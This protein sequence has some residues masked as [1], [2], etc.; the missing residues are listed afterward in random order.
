MIAFPVARIEIGRSARKVS[1]A[2]VPTERVATRDVVEPQVDQSGAESLSVFPSFFS[3]RHSEDA[4]RKILT[5]VDTKDQYRIEPMLNRDR[6]LKV[7]TKLKAVLAELDDAQIG[8]ILG[9]LIDSTKALADPVISMAQW[10]T[11]SLQLETVAGLLNKHANDKLPHLAYL[12][13]IVKKLEYVCRFSWKLQ[14]YEALIEKFT[15]AFVKLIVTNSAANT[16]R[17]AM[18]TIEASLPLDI[19]SLGGSLGHQISFSFDDEG[20]GKTY[21]ST[22]GDFGARLKLPFFKFGGKISGLTGK[23]DYCRTAR[24]HA[25]CYFNELLANNRKSPL[26]NPY[27]SRRSTLGVKDKANEVEDFYLVQKD[28]VLTEK[29]IA[30]NFS[31]FLSLDYSGSLVQESEKLFERGYDLV[32]ST[33]LRENQLILHQPQ[34]TPR[35]EAVQGAKKKAVVVNGKI[36]TKAG[37]LSAKA[38][39]ETLVV[40]ASATAQGEWSERVTE[41]TRYATLCELLDNKPANS[42]EVFKKT[43][44]RDVQAAGFAI[45]KKVHANWYPKRKNEVALDDVT[46]TLIAVEYHRHPENFTPAFVSSMSHEPAFARYVSKKAPVLFLK[47]DVDLL[48]ADFKFLEDLHAQRAMGNVNVDQSIA[49]F[50]KIYDAANVE[51]CL[52][53]MAV[54]TAYFYEQLGDEKPKEF[55]ERLKNLETRIFATGIPHRPDVLRKI[56]G[57]TQ[58]YYSVTSDKTFEFTLKSEFK[59]LF[60]RTTAPGLGFKWNRKELSHYNPSRSGISHNVDLTLSGTA[61]VDRQVMKA[62]SRYLRYE[63]AY[64][65][66]ELFESDYFANLSAKGTYAVRYFLPKDA[67]KMQMVKLDSRLIGQLGF[68]LSPSVPIGVPGFGNIAV[69]V[70]YSSSATT[71]LKDMPSPD[72]MYYFNVHYM[73]A[74]FTGTIPMNEETLEE[75]LRQKGQDSYWHVLVRNHRDALAQL[76]VNIAQGKL[77]AEFEHLKSRYLSYGA[78][79]QDREKVEA[80]QRVFLASATHFN[81]TEM[82]YQIALESF[83]GFMRTLYKHWKWTRELSEAF[84]PYQYEFHSTLVV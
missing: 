27:L 6:A 40:E 44:Q 46:C 25:I 12:K 30:D 32:P 36:D 76:F 83:K 3:R 37:V 80:A 75:D 79:K 7:L 52:K 60:M 21:R 53:N 31:L 68:E 72:T 58:H 70:T 82:D 57:A 14:A 13:S 33:L 65:M 51:E 20:Y 59:P 1:I 15:A 63:G 28:Y 23:Y 42:K 24:D 10:A 78:S 54:L 74:L 29:A 5:S 66:A 17:T 18:G 45:R 69:G 38:G 47:N 34:V 73:H 8:E 84:D 67:G 55:A 26:I 71:L 61:G 49:A 81:D 62:L 50:Y 39:L 41:N 16:V 22:T 43:L 35:A 56:A 48:S 64:D 11:M 9:Q 4:R 2:T 19:L 77:A